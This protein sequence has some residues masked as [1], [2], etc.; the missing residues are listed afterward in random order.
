MKPTCA[1]INTARGGIVNEEDLYLALSNKIIR[2]AYFDVLTNE[3]AKKDE[4]LLTL[5]N[6]YL[7]PHI[8]SRSEEAEKNNAN[9][10]T[11]IIIKA[12]Q[13]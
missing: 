4:K 12:L 3:P 10:A 13:N 8:A 5:S 2:C 7:T 9:M 1:I 11:Q 6:F